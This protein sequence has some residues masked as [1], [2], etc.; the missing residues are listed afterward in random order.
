MAATAVSAPTRVARADHGV[1]RAH[2]RG[3]ALA[4]EQ[5]PVD[6][7]GSLLDL[8]V[9]G[10]LLAGPDHEA[11]AHRQLVD[12]Q[13]PLDP[14]RHHGHVLGPELEQGAEGEAGPALGPG[15][16]QPPGED[17]HGDHGGDLEVDRVAVRALDGERERHL[18]AR[19]AGVAEEE[20]PHRPPEGG[21]GAD[22]DEG[23]HGGGPVPEVGPGGA[24]ERPAAPH[25]HGGGQGQ[26]E[27]LPVLELEGGDHG[28]EE[29]GE[30]EDGAD[31]HPLAQ[32]GGRVLGRRLALAGLGGR[33]RRLGQ[34]RRVPGRFHGCHQRRRWGAVAVVVDGGPLGGVVDR[35]PDAVQVVQAALDPAGAGGARHAGD[36]QLGAGRRRADGHTVRIPV[37]GI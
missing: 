19:H 2:L 1:A 31:E 4:G 26:R 11:V 12:G 21:Q 25:H 30:G 17:E 3:H 16:E 15:L 24:V 20:R 29:H 10:H 14:V 37:P 28:H 18:H 6:G 7:R 34:R 13:P 9:G 8:A 27:P 36:G 35:G 5:G 22:R 32:G 33:C 23:V